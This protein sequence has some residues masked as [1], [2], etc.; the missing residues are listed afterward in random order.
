[1]KVRFT[2]MKRTVSILLLLATMVSFAS[3]SEK[4]PSSS[5][6]TTMSGTK[7]SADTT[8]YEI[9]YEEDSLPADLDFGGIKI[10]I[11]SRDITGD[12]FAFPEIS[13]EELTSDVVNDSIYN[14]ERFV[15]DRLNI[16]IVNEQVAEIR[17]EM[18]KQI[19]SGDDTHQ[20]HA[21]DGIS[22]ARVSMNNYY[23]DLYSLDYIDFDKPWW[24]QNFNAEAEV[25]DK[26]Y[27]ST[28]AFSLSLIRDLYVVYYNKNLAEDFAASMPELSDVYS[29]VDEGKWTFDKLVALSGDIYTDLNGNS[30]RDG[31]DLFGLGY[32][33]TSSDAIFGSFDIDVL[34]RTSDGWFELN[35]N[36]DKLYSALEKMHNL[37]YNTQG[38]LAGAS[39][40]AVYPYDGD[41][42]Y[43]FFASGSLLF[44]VNYMSTAETESLR[45]MQDEY[46]ILP[47]PKYDNN[48]KDYYSCTSDIPTCFSIPTTNNDPN[49]SA[50]V[51]EA[52]A[53]YSY[54]DTRP[55][56]LDTALKGKYMN[57]PDSRRMVDYIIDGYKV[58][59]SWIYFDTLSDEY[60]ASFRYMLV[61][62]ET[63]YASKHAAK[64]KAIN[65]SLKAY[66]KAFEALA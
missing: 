62:G 59:A 61:D 9:V 27:L 16:E 65:R 56:Y 10:S 11:M 17:D 45:N 18:D 24:S 21:A 22:L 64:E 26:L 48:Q 51:L 13:V 7:E 53:S 28:G 66:R 3:C 2:T 50:A 57:D 39:G 31:E 8:A 35:V 38:C 14:R 4:T 58:D 33:K 54:R 46:G 1:M 42:M 47:F 19:N 5:Q 12:K 41:D 49:T 40:D 52:L 37:Y 25:F 15:E 36:T 55:A 32:T 34:S 63:G 6:D 23:V 44:I 29:I 60:P 20:I 30:M 43:K